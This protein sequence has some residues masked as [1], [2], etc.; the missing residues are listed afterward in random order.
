[1][2]HK[3]LISIGLI[4][5]FSLHILAGETRPG[6]AEFYPSEPDS[7]LVIHGRVLDGRNGSPLPYAHIYVLN[8]HTGTVSNEQ[9]H[10]A[11]DISGLSQSD[12]L[13]FQY[14]GYET[15]RITIRQLK[16]SP[17]VMMEENIINLSETL[18]FG[19]TPD[20][21]DIVKKVLENK[22]RNYKRTT[23]KR[24]VFIRDRSNQDITRFKLKYKKSSI[25]EIDR[26]MIGMVEEKLPRNFTSFTDF[27][28][29][30]YVNKNT[31]DSV[32]LK[33]DPVRMVSLEEEDLSEFEQFTTIFENLFENT[34][35]DEYWKV[36]SG[37]FGDKIDMDEE[38]DT[39]V[40][41]TLNVE[42][43]KDSLNQHQWP[44]RYY[45][46]GVRYRQAFSTLDNSDQWEFLHNTGRYKYS[47]AGGTRIN[48]EDVYI[49]DFE[50]RHRGHYQGR[51]FIAM[52]TYALVSASFDYAPG[53]TGIEIELLGIGYS[54]TGF[55]GSVFFEKRDNTYHLKYLSYNSS[56]D[57][58]I[59][60]KLML[61][62]K[63][64][65]WLFDKT[66][67]EIKIRLHL[68]VSMR[69]SV[70]YLVLERKEISDEEFSGF[71]EKKKMDIIYVDQ[72]DDKL[73]EGYTI[74]EPIE[75]MREYRKQEVGWGF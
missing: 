62:K 44:V 9:G 63:R 59:N 45:K 39:L 67:M 34:E 16:E 10:Y 71:E 58:R 4:L 17:D 1:M 3:Y 8:R 37:I 66:L 60:R 50:P 64:E 20:P 2:T 25:P 65:R 41:D 32:T 69:E 42:P 28:G 30:L 75:Q 70:E 21:R 53:K 54:E 11:I 48:G 51:M 36:R 24:R 27:L 61:I 49:I 38:S 72:F 22:D 43:S 47:L 46:S 56:R 35:G 74:I 7:N 26:D 15:A 12:T 55:G 14:M 23:S 19:T 5:N 29:N 68:A 18:I 40:S 31:E 33:I 57:A 73:W 6:G 52:E 13:R